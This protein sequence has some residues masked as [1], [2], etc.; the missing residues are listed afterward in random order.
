MSIK[1]APTE[2]LF[3]RDWSRGD[4]ILSAALC[5]YKKYSTKAVRNQ[6]LFAHLG[7]RKRPRKQGDFRPLLRPC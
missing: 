6:P 7:N 4:G 5:R 2:G 3:R 1:K